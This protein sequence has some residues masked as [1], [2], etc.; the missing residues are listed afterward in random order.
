[1]DGDGGCIVG[2]VHVLVLLMKPQ[3]VLCGMRSKFLLSSL[4]QSLLL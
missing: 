1:M 4:I 3:F 2:G